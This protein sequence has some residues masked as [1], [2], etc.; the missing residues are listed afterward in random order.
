MT[1]PYP[2]RTN[3]LALIGFLA[4]F[5]IPIAGIVLGVMAQRQ[6]AVTHE[7]GRGLARAAIII[8]AVF[9]TAAAIYFVVFISIF[10][11]AISQAPF[12]R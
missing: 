7:G 1:T 2:P 8:G 6:I 3:T 11:T 4:S 12:L 5:I 9:T 10:I